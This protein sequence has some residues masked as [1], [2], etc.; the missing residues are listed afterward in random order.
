MHKTGENG[1]YANIETIIPMVGKKPP[2]VKPVVFDLDD[3]GTY[4]T[5]QSLPRYIQEGIAKSEGF[6]FTGLTV[7][8]KNNQTQP[9]LPD[10]SSAPPVHGGGMYPPVDDQYGEPPVGGFY[11]IPDQMPATV[12]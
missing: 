8:P 4:P 11:D 5:F 6:E 2:A 9:P 12:F 10:D 3:A 7:A 1:D